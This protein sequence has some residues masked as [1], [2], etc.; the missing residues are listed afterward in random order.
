MGLLDEVLGQAAQGGASPL[1]SA[2]NALLVGTPGGAGTQPGSGAAPSAPDGG[3][4]GG[5]NGFLEK[6]QNAGHGD[7]VSSWTQPGPNKPIAPSQL[8]AALG[9]KT[10]SAMAQHTGLNEQDLLTQLAQNIPQI[11]AKL[12]ANGT[13]PNLQ[14]LAAALTQ[15][16]R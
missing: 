14:Q 4:A 16:Q 12:T 1:A 8:G 9:K 3:L 13:I 2:L 7:A 10:V 5:L 11:I 6:L 15:P